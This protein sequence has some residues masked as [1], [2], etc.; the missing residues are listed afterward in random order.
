MFKKL[1]CKCFITLG[2]LLFFTLLIPL[3]SYNVA[4][5]EAAIIDKEKNEDY[6]LNL[7]SITLVKGKSFTLKVY[8]LS[9]NAKISFKS[10]DAEIASVSDDGIVTAN[11]VGTTNI[12]VTIKD[13]SLVCEVIVGPPAFSIKLTRSR[14]VLGLNNSDTLKVILKPSNSAE[15]ARFS[16]Y[17]PTIVSVSTGGRATAK[18]LGMTYLFAE[19]D[20]TN[21]DGT[22]KFAVCSVIVVNTDDVSLLETYFSEHPEL[23]S[24]SEADLI[25][26]LDDFFNGKSDGTAASAKIVEVSKSTMVNNLNRYLE[27]K[28]DLTGRRTEAAALLKAASNKVEVISENATK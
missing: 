22:R 26:A 20:A 25:K 27:D 21:N 1:L 23:D 5:A 24:I 19:I 2:L 4:T 12:T 14:I 6:R 28:F 11:K 7:K 18:E 3:T 17:A 8:N 10:D 9:E 13:T 15:D 16:S